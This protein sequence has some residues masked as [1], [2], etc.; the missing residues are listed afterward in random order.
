M[1]TELLPKNI[2]RS[3]VDIWSQ[4]ETRVGQQGSLSRIW[5]KRGTRPRKVRQQQFIST[6]IY[7]AACHETGESFALILPYANTQAMNKFLED[8][9]HTIEGNRHIALIVDNAG[10]HTA[11]KLTVPSNITLI[12]LPPYAPELNAMEQVWE[13]IKNHYLSNQC[14]GLYEDIVSMACYAWNQLAQNVDLVKSIM[15]RDWINTPR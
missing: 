13:W 15:Y 1:L 5:A 4:D 11:K 14:Y 2:D 9:S 10:W 8:L 12:P 7:G 3:K 6:Y